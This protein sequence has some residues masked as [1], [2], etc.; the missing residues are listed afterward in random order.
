L[1]HGSGWKGKAINFIEIAA[2]QPPAQ[3]LLFK[4]HCAAKEFMLYRLKELNDKGN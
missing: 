2:G 1:L 4:D 3:P